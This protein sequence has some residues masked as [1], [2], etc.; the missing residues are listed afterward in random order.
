MSD[1]IFEVRDLNIT[2]TDGKRAIPAVD[3]LNLSLHRGETVG[4]IGESGSGK[5]IS[6]L[7]AMGLLPPD[8]WKVEGSVLLNG[9]RLSGEDAEVMRGIRGEKI[10]MIL[11][12]PIS[13]FDPC[14][15]IEKHFVET[16]QAHRKVSG[17]QV[18]NK[19]VQ[20]MEQLHIRDSR[21]VLHNYPFQCSGGMLQRIMI[22]MALM[23][24][25]EIMIADEPTT[26]LDRT[27]Q[28]EIIRLLR[29]L[30]NRTGMSMI[31]VSHDLNVMSSLADTI[32]VM[33]SGQ[34]IERAS[35]A[36]LIAAP[37]HPYTRGLLGSRPQ[38]SKDRLN[39]M[40]GNPPILANRVAGGCQFM[41]RCEC[42]RKECKDYAQTICRDDGNHFVDC[43]YPEEGAYDSR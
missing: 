42:R 30:K 11:Q 39:V 40:E 12:N 37:R 1:T 18:L 6:C 22:A 24:E 23:L 43:L 32:Y 41:E 4:I 17:T 34:L 20:L 7:A 5:T 21:K 27:I 16:A 31:L 26:A 25:P 9:R 28:Y 33:Y 35:A 3:H 29:E 14:A 13:A 36:E 8:K 19:A 15:T 38:F 2:L 10:S